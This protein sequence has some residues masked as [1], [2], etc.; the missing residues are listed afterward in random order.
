MCAE[1]RIKLLLHFLKKICFNWR[2]NALQNFV[3]FCQTS[4]WISRRYTCI[5]S[6]LNPFPSPSP[7]HPSRL[8][9]SPCFEFPEPYS[10]FL[11]AIYFTDGNVS[12]HITLCIHLTLSSHLPMSINFLCL[13]LHCYPTNKLFNTIF[14]DSIYMP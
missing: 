12:F 10:K 11:L 1:S 4:A 8:I 13:F 3:I 5:P 6:L 14:L 7:S 2:I 9:Q